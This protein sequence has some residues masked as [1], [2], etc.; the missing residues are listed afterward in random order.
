MFQKI[1]IESIVS[2]RPLRSWRQITLVRKEQ[3]TN[4]SSFRQTRGSADRLPRHR[5]R[6]SS[7]IQKGI[8]LRR[9]F[10][11]RVFGQGGGKPPHS[12][13]LPRSR[14]VYS[15]YFLSTYTIVTVFFFGEYGKFRIEKYRNNYWI[16]APER[17]YGI[18]FK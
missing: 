15:L 16:I 1:G 5:G 3:A 2:L 12:T 17:K 13:N 4:G 10:S 8:R 9:S 7:A 11:A 18:L 6:T 14:L